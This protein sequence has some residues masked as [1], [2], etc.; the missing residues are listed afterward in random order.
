MKLLD[1]VECFFFGHSVLLS[2]LKRTSDDSVE[3]K[4]VRCD[5]VLKGDCGLTILSRG[6]TI[7]S[8][9]SKSADKE[10]NDGN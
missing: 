6:A 8:A 4:C 9:A 3:W 5:E 2:N 1:A 10:S 7:I